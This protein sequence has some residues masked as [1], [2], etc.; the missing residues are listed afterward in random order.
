M[1]LNK[2]ST[3]RLQLVKDKMIPSPCFLLEEKLL[4]QNLTLI[5]KV[6]DAAGINIILAFKAFAMW[7]TFPIIREYI[8]GA[9]ASSLWEAQLCFEEMGTKAHTYAAAYIPEDFEEVMKRSSHITFNSLSQYA[10][11]KD[12]VLSSTDHI[13][14]GLRVNPEYSEVETEMY[15][16]AS[17]GSRLGIA[18]GALK[19]GLPEGIE[20]LHFHVLCESDS[21]QL[22]RTLKVFETKYGYLF[23]QIKWVNMGGGHLMTRKGYHTDHL[24][25]ILLDFK[26]R[27]GL[28]VI[29]EPGSAFAWQTGDLHSTV[30]DVVNNHGIKTLM[31]D[32]SFTAH[33]PDTLEMPYRP[34]IEGASSDVKTGGHN[35]RIGGM[36]CLA[37]DYMREYSF[38]EP[39]K[40]GDRIVLK[41][42]MHY[43]MVKTSTFNGVKHPSIGMRRLDGT[44]EIF[45][46]FGYEDYRGRLS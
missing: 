31:L 15:N 3:N 10:F 16:P 26:K 29:L 12:Q 11:Y 34:E 41:D 4:R 45:K 28:D 36:S 46:E 5:K 38:E 37:G 24:V 23:S 32:V 27:T 35:Y 7:K 44:V 9:T 21:F 1:E 14:C 30:L 42:M 39:V 2:F 20:G 13:S 19:N 17:P 8:V 22:E 43:T 25:K 18:S 33:M 40:I 6:K